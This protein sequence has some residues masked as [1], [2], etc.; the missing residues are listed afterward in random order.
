MDVKL[1]FIK[2][3][4]FQDDI[5]VR[6]DFETKN[7]IELFEGKSEFMPADWFEIKFTKY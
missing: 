6:S 7:Q 3:F 1:N 5:S 4:D 2:S